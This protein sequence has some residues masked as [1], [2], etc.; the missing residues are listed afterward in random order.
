MGYAEYLVSQFNASIGQK[1]P[2][3]RRD[4]IIKSPEEAAKPFLFPPIKTASDEDKTGKKE[5]W[6]VRG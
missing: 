3:I 1:P 5:W 4:P 6:E 2:V